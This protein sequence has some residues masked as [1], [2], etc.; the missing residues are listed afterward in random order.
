MELLHYLAKGETCAGVNS[1][2]S[3]CLK[4]RKKC[5]NSPVGDK[6]PSGIVQVCET[7]DQTDRQTKITNFKKKKEREP[8]RKE[9]RRVSSALGFV[10]RVGVM[11]S[12]AISLSNTSLLARGDWWLSARFFI[13]FS[14]HQG[15]RPRSSGS[16]GTANELPR[17]GL[18]LCVALMLSHKR[19]R[20][21]FAGG[22]VFICLGLYRLILYHFG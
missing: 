4:V 14:P 13:D 7:N 9:P 22:I 2:Y 12:P 8:E 20:K 1:C 3:C 15:D 21:L 10:V 17:P 6:M 18:F 11:N 5:P 19:K 16:A